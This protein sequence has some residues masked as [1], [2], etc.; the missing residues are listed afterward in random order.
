[1]K[2]EVNK[3]ERSE[4]VG[5][6]V[7]RDC[8]DVAFTPSGKR[9]Q[10]SND[11][12]GI[13]RLVRML[14]RTHPQLVV[15]EASGGYETAALERLIL[16]KIP[17]ALLNPRH[18]HNFARASGRLAKTD[19]IDAEVL[20]HFADVMRP[21]SKQL[22]DPETRTLRA[23]VSRRH[24]LVQ[25]VTAE[26]NRRRTSLDIVRDGF[27]ATIRCFKKE[28]AA[29]DKK[30]STLIEGA[31][32]FREK[33]ALLRSTPGVGAVVAA[34]LLARLPELGSL[35]RKKIAAL[36]GVAPFNRDSGRFKGKRSI[37]GGR[38]DVREILYMATLVGLRLNPSIRNFHDRLR[39][40]GKSP[41]IALTACM[42]KLLV[43]L[44]AMVKSSTPFIESAASVSP[45]S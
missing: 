4:F 5:I 32:A 2:Q 35:D 12:G 13:S 25:M 42:R 23:L 10:V 20:A 9:T 40:A 31:A 21:S 15:L 3:M 18:V 39:S 36:V 44:N 6:D 27:A 38:G 11:R 30:M 37:W 14:E 17:V 43:M 28:I 22:A 7:S 1:V 19:V 8:L 34:T 26:L 45:S 24:Q 16:K 41:K 29:I 33:A